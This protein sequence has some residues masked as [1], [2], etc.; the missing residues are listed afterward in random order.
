MQLCE[1]SLQAPEYVRC[2]SYSAQNMMMTTKKRTQDACV[3]GFLC[4][5]LTQKFESLIHGSIYFDESAHDWHL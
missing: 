3:V 2:E 4:K 1:P 5:R